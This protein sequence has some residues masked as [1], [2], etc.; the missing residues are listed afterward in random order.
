MQ[1]EP[2]NP[3]PH[4]AEALSRNLPNVSSPATPRLALSQSSFDLRR[5]NS[6]LRF[7]EAGRST[8]TS[9][10]AH[11]FGGAFS[12]LGPA[13][14]LL[15]GKVV[16]LVRKLEGRDVEAKRS[17]ALS[18]GRLACKD[19]AVSMVARHVGKLTKR[20][21]DIDVP[22]KRAVLDALRMLAEHGQACAVGLHASDVM[23]CL[24]DDDIM[25]R[26][27]AAALCRVI[28]EEG[29][30]MHLTSHVHKLMDCFRASAGLI[31]PLEALR[32][33]SDAGEAGAVSHEICQLVKALSNKSL[34]I[35]GA[36]CETLAAIVQGGGGELLHRMPSSENDDRYSPNARSEQDV[37]RP[38]L[39][40][41]VR[42]VEEESDLDVQASAVRALESI[43][44]MDP[45]SWEI[46]RERYSLSLVRVLCR[47]EGRLSDQVIRM[48]QQILRIEPDFDE[49]A[50]S[51]LSS[52]A[53]SPSAEERSDVSDDDLMN[54][55]QDQVDCIICHERLAVGSTAATGGKATKK[56]QCGHLF[57]RSCLNRWFSASRRV[58]KGKNTC[59]ICRLE[60][61]RFS[62]IDTM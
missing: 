25:L 34:R 61:P 11:A 60:V 37:Q 24:K 19:E 53:G 17:A 55:C 36:A 10:V 32:A 23:V 4:Y 52:Q 2:L 39:G 6:S 50:S 31:A 28:A 14:V 54:D 3:R 51:E 5:S 30:A 43:V 59:P 62:G 38:A 56:L 40:A 47:M 15:P 1:S 9:F 48:L 35:R 58:N 41:L 7:Q 45:E 22:T 27:K 16:D 49:D 12:L 29:G 44:S 13:D 57:H 26:R 46:L 21:H 8:T 33:M 18:L 20:L 42:L